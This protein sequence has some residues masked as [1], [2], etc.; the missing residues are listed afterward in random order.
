MTRSCF[1]SVDHNTVVNKGETKVEQEQEQVQKIEMT[2][3]VTSLNQLVF[4]ALCASRKENEI[5]LES[6]G[7]T[8]RARRLAILS[9]DLEKCFAWI[10]YTERI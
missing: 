7:R 3:E 10:D 8:A 5:E 1:E 2:E 4:E 9:T 6:Q